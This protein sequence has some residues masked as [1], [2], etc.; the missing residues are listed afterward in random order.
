[1]TTF[2]MS[3]F[4]KGARKDWLACIRKWSKRSR[5]NTVASGAQSKKRKLPW[6]A[7]EDRGVRWVGSRSRLRR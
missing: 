7:S 4:A 5:W 6:L 1:M 2:D 3:E